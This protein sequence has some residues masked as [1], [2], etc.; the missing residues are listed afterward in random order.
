MSPET[1]FRDSLRAELARINREL[2]DVRR[3]SAPDEPRI[4]EI[5]RLARGARLL[6]AILAGIG[7]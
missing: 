5:M 3:F 2:R 1:S 7:R 4:S 6:S